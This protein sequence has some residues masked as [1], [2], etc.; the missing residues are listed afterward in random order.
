MLLATLDATVLNL[1]DLQNSL[2]LISVLFLTLFPA[3]FFFPRMRKAGDDEPRKDVSELPT[4]LV[5]LGTK[6]DIR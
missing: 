4:P 5:H 1:A 6:E 3:G 2:I